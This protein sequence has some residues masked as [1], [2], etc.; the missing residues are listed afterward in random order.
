MTLIH[1][2]LMR[3]NRALGRI[4]SS[5]H[6]LRGVAAVCSTPPSSTQQMRTLFERAAPT[7]H[8][9]SLSDDPFLRPRL[10]SHAEHMWQLADDSR[11]PRPATHAWFFALQEPAPLEADQ[12]GYVEATATRI[13]A[14]PVAQAGPAE[15]PATGAAAALAEA[16]IGMSLSSVKKKRVTKMNKHKRRKRRKRDR[17]K[18]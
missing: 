11:V 18:N 12:S 8:R 6:Q 3:G 14:A 4:R 1:A 10:P 2:A 9:I 7:C 15:A 17:M 5:A 16:N 13:T